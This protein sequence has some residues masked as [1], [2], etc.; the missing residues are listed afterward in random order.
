MNWFERVDGSAKTLMLVQKLVANTG[1]VIE[2]MLWEHGVSF[3]ELS[4]GVPFEA[5][6]EE[7]FPEER[8]RKSHVE[9]DKMGYGM[10]EGFYNFA[11]R[12][13]VL[14]NPSDY[15][16]CHEAGHALDHALNWYGTDIFIGRDDQSR[17]DHLTGRWRM[18]T[19]REPFSQYAMTHPR[20]RFAE[21]FAAYL[22]TEPG[23]FGRYHIDRLRATDRTAAALMRRIFREA[24]GSAFE[25]AIR[26]AA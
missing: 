3:L 4:P 1:P 11:K 19:P 2:Q 7:Y 10:V 20:E 21:A 22:D 25:L 14:R 12:M 17:F 9:M 26:P 15:V 8:D 18:R 5:I 23:T 16:L 13:I 6:P 24:N